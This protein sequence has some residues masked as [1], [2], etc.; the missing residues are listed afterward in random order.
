MLEANKGSTGITIASNP[1]KIKGYKK[2]ASIRLKSY[3][4]L[5]GFSCARLGSRKNFCT[6]NLADGTRMG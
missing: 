4:Q 5:Y 3:V 6:T 2:N 1:N